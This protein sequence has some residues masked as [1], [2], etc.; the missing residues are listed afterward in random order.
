MLGALKID[1][2]HKRLQ[3]TL[4]NLHADHVASD[5]LMNLEGTLSLNRREGSFWHFSTGWLPPSCSLHI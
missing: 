1:E 4:E 2:R 3:C 5:S